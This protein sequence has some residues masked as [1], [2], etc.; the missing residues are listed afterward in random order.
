M[1]HCTFNS[2]IY[3]FF[4][5]SYNCIHAKSR[6][7]QGKVLTLLK[8]QSRNVDSGG[9]K[10]TFPSIFSF[11]GRVLSMFRQKMEEPNPSE[12]DIK[13]FIPALTYCVQT[14]ECLFHN[15]KS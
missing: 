13:L 15:W 1:C 12:T 9:K 4:G 2:L 3:T 7:K 8:H 11:T 14:E 5:G 6:Y 10:T